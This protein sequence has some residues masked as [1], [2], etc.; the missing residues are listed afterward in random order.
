MESFDVSFVSRFR[1]K[2]L[3]QG[4]TIDIK[5]LVGSLGWEPS[6]MSCLGTVALVFLFEI[7][8]LVSPTW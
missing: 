7:C 5:C 6:S 4:L 3:A 2:I 8:R 1:Q